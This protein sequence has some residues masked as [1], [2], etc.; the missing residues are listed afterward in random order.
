M[1][2][3][4]MK[5]GDTVTRM[6]CGFPMQLKVSTVTDDRII[7]GPWT[8]SKAN[9]AEIDE[10]LGWD[11][12]KTGSYLYHDGIGNAVHVIKGEDSV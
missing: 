11:E 10:E 12:R 9:G 3:E 1:C 6:M 4:D 8:F 7:C 2:L 5:V